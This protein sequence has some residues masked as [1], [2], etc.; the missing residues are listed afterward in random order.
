MSVTGKLMT[1]HEVAD[2]LD[3]IGVLVG[4][5]DSLE[6]SVSWSLPYERDDAPP[7]TVEV[8]ASYRIGNLQ[9]QGGM[10]VVGGYGDNG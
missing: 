10:R 9:G 7:G 8:Y 5:G 2:L 3:G 6:G 4:T 1:L